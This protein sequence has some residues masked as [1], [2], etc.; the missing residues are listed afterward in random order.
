MAEYQ[1]KLTTEE[2]RMLEGLLEDA[3]RYLRAKHGIDPHTVYDMRIKVV[4]DV[5]EKLSNAVHD[6][7]KQDKE[8]KS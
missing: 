1:V 2:L 4:D 3:P 6:S 5:K 8:S 7:V